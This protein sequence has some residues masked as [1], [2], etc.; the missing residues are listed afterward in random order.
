[1]SEPEFTWKEI[2][3]LVSKGEDLN[4]DQAHWAMNTL[5]SGTATDAQIAAFIMGLRVKGETAVEVQGLVDAMLANAVRVDLDRVAVD[6]VGTG[7]DGAHTVNIS[8][9]AALTVAGAGAPVLKHGNRAISSKSGT[10]DVLEALGVAVD[11]PPLMVASCVADAGIAFCFAPSHH[12]A[13]RHA[14]GVRKELGVPTV[15][16]VLGPLANPGQ[17]AAALIGCAD[18]RMA[19]ILAQVQQARGLKSIVVRSEEGLD[20][21]STSSPS[22]IWDVTDGSVRHCVLNP[23]ELELAPATI[24]QL[25]GGDPAFNAEVIRGIVSGRTDGNYGAIRDVVALNA[26]GALV[27]YDAAAGL[28]NFGPVSDSVVARIGRALPVAYQSLDSGA[29]ATVLNV[30]ISVSQRFALSAQ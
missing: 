1:M 26:A 19:P 11:M 22:Q 6:V 18:L 8:T 13:M 29:A 15:F 9:M 28:A 4:L 5:M 10:A 30:L 7:G 14:A 23:A 16:N 27:A 3:T 2:L 20:E 24:E 25:R 17:P 12:P 21:L